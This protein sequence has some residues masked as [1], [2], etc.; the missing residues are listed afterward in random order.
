MKYSKK[1]DVCQILVGAWEVKMI[2]ESVDLGLG[3]CI[4]TIFFKP[5]KILRDGVWVDYKK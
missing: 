3:E 5:D 4:H 1:M 2:P